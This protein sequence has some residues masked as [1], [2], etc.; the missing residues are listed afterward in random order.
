[1]STPMDYQ[2]KLVFDRDNDYS[3]P[4]LYRRVVGEVIN[5]NVT[6]PNNSNVVRS[7]YERSKAKPLDGCLLHFL[8]YLK[9]TPSK[10]LAY[11]KSSHFLTSLHLIGHMD[12]D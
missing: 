9:G 4:S 1:M 12:V 11:S 3:S 2:T 7:V 6:G 8:I 5:L 10:S